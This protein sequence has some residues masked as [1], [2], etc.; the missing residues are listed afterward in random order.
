MKIYDLNK[1]TEGLEEVFDTPY[2][3]IHCGICGSTQW[4]EEVTEFKNNTIHIKGSC[5]ECGKF[6]QW[7][8]YSESHIIKEFLKT[9][10]KK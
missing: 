10:I 1:K 5:K 8:P 4:D 6:I 9:Q 7:I 2:K 3:K